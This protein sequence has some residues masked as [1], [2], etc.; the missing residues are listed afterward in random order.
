ML[1]PVASSSNSKAPAPPLISKQIS[2][3]GVGKSPFSLEQV[4]VEECSE[5]DGFEEEEVD[6]DDSEDDHMGGSKFFRTRV[7]EGAGG[8]SETPLASAQPSTRPSLVTNHQLVVAIPGTSNFSEHACMGP[9]GGSPVVD[10]QGIFLS[11][12]C[13]F[14]P[15]QS[16]VVAAND[17]NVRTVVVS[18]VPLIPEDTPVGGSGMVLG[19]Y[20]IICNLKLLRCVQE[21]IML[22]CKVV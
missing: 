18:F 9:N 21:L 12:G 5:D 14:D 20:H 19:V 10:D 15:I 6:Y 4:L 17:D 1:A 22:L 8:P 13:G 11:A 3:D 7:L 16:K 2:T